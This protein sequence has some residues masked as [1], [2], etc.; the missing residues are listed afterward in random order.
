MTDAAALVGRWDIV[1]WEQLYDDGRRELPMGDA[2][3]GFIR[4]LPDGDMICMICRTD[5]SSFQTGGQWNA[6]DAEKARAYQTMLSYAGRFRV[7]GDV[8]VHSVEFSLFPNWKGGRQS[9]RFRFLPDG[10]IALEARLEEGTP[11]A[12]TAR[13]VWR[14]H[15][16]EGVSE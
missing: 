7:E 3:E 4:Y 5:R 11:E 10:S 15:T 13:L 8:V 14:R 2:L 12:R 9:R 1:S 16:A 6:T